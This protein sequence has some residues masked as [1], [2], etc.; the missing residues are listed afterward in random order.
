MFKSF[1]FTFFSLCVCSCTNTELGSFAPSSSFVGKKNIVINFL[2]K[3]DKTGCKQQGKYGMDNLAVFQNDFKLVQNFEI[4][5]TKGQIIRHYR[6]DFEVDQPLKN[7]KDLFKLAALTYDTDHK[8]EKL[9]DVAMVFL[10]KGTEFGLTS[11]F[12]APD[13]KLGFV[14]IT[15]GDDKLF[16]SLK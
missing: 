4:R 1:V 5:N 8:P 16:E 14:E 7:R 10:T 11:R 2:T 3:S 15:I 9:V 6:T 12:E 13:P